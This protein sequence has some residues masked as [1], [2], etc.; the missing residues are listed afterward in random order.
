MKG[1]DRDKSVNR[2]PSLRIFWKSSVT[3][4]KISTDSKI[5]PELEKTL[6]TPK[7]RSKEKC[8]CSKSSVEFDKGNQR[9][10]TPPKE[11]GTNNV[12]S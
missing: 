10:L 12:G 6:K 8:E 3:V 1:L 2:R 5:L 7:G 9:N 11:V 4:K